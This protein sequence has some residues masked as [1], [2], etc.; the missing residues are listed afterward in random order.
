MRGGNGEKSVMKRLDGDIWEMNGQ[1][2]VCVCLYNSF[3]YNNILLAYYF[4]YWLD[5]KDIVKLEVFIIFIHITY[6]HLC[7]HFLG[8]SFV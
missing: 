2:S 7:K 3:P 5:R 8:G 4:F 1:K 6:L